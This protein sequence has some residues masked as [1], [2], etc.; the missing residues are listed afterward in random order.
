MQKATVDTLD[1][2]LDIRNRWLGVG[3]LKSKYNPTPYHSKTREGK[4][5]KWKERAQQAAEHLSK[6]QWGIQEDTEVGRSTEEHSQN[7]K[8]KFVEYEDWEI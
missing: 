5:I 2:E 4:H 8:E 3:Q 1:R 6:K 7:N